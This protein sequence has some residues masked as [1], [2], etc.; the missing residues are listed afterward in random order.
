MEERKL[1]TFLHLMPKFRECVEF[2]H[3]IHISDVIHV[4]RHSVTLP[5]QYKSEPTVFRQYSAHAVGWTTGELGFD[6]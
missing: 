6:S 2:I 3:V 1:T 5:Y 4:L